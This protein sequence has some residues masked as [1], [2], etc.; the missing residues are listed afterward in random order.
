MTGKY[1]IRIEE[2]NKHNIKIETTDEFKKSYFCRIYESAA[3]SIN[4]IAEKQKTKIDDKNKFADPKEMIYRRDCY[5]YKHRTHDPVN[6]I[7]VFSGERGS[8]KSSALASFVNLLAD[9]KENNKDFDD[10]VEVEELKKLHKG[11]KYYV[12]KTLDP[13]HFTPEKN[14]LFVIISSLFQEFKIKYRANSPGR[15]DI[16]NEIMKLFEKTFKAVQ[17]IDLKHSDQAAAE[18]LGRLDELS[19]SMDL[20]ENI[21]LLVT[22]FMKF[23]QTIDG[24][25]FNFFVIPIDDLDMNVDHAFEMLEQIRKFLIQERIIIL[26]AANVRQLH[27]E[28]EENYFD[29]YEK[30]FN[31]RHRDNYRDIDVKR[32]A[33]DYMSKI[34]PPSRRLEIP[35]LDIDFD[36]TNLEIVSKSDA[37]D[38]KENN[39]NTSNNSSDKDI[40]LQK[41]ILDMI[42]K[43]TGLIFVP[44]ENQLHP[45]IP[46]NLR[47]LHQLVYL[48]ISM[49]VAIKKEEEKIIVDDKE[50][51][52]EKFIIDGE[53]IKE[54]FYKFKDYIMK[55]WIPYHLASKQ[56]DIFEN[57][58]SD[59]NRINKY[60]L[61]SINA[62]GNQFKEKIVLKEVELEN[63]F[64]DEILREKEESIENTLSK[65]VGYLV[66]KINPE[67]YKEN[68][69]VIEI[70][71]LMQDLITNNGSNPK[72]NSLRYYFEKIRY[73]AKSSNICK[74]YK[75]INEK[76]TMEAYC[77]LLLMY[78]EAIEKLTD[79]KWLINST[80]EPIYWIRRVLSQKPLK[81]TVV[82]RDIYTMVS[83]NDPNF[84]DVNKISDPFN[85]T[86]NNSMGDILLLISKYETYFESEEALSFISAVKMY[87]SMLLYENMFFKSE[88]T[89]EDPEIGK[90]KSELKDLIMPIQLLIG[91]TTYFPHAV[92]L[93]S[94]KID[95]SRKLT[96]SEH[97]F[98]FQVEK[99]KLD[100]TNNVLPYFIQYYGARRPKRPMPRHIYDTTY[101]ADVRD[102]E[103]EKIGEK[104]K[105]RFDILSY[106][107]NTLNPY[108][109]HY[110]FFNEY[111]EENNE[112]TKDQIVW[113]KSCKHL[114][115][116][117]DNKGNSVI[118]PI[119]FLPLYSVDIMLRLIRYRHISAEPNF[120]RVVED[121]YHKII[122]LILGWLNTNI[123]EDTE[124]YI[125]KIISVNPICEEIAVHTANNGNKEKVTKIVLKKDIL[126]DT[127][128]S[129]FPKIIENSNES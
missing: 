77:L 1:T 100:L 32:M 60:L 92:E 37:E 68:K 29:F 97:D 27:L 8:G 9:N 96:K 119:P 123:G 113:I 67:E 91:G 4:D 30:R 64:D 34:I 128:N 73:Y 75:L 78:Q 46:T 72:I 39:D 11:N 41:T 47:S 5:R 125:K 82:D 63:R 44:E 110:R 86:S 117:T 15:K 74:Y 87:Y 51:T 107:V 105:A 122:G 14:I 118:P 85:Y 6:N 108:F 50:I 48:M 49:D 79:T 61:Q 62:V 28:L 66:E 43:R 124:K 109:T 102:V 70:K 71:N 59:L 81:K 12:L 80:L 42:W 89:V 33:S 56:Q 3:K 16:I 17:N 111:D 99:E 24:I 58:P 19:I 38:K 98:Y 18:S 40:N 55:Y 7:I 114:Y 53:K 21:G 69:N 76:N 126:S 94:C 95:N 88:L 23:M 115:V 112:F 10:S 25:D 101:Q 93:V 57:I 83:V 104:D 36:N 35:H 2:K 13:S 106:L 65:L 54:N 120:N 127:F 121:Y 90:N 52:K 84:Y 31:A 26:M 45:V 116:S 103:D 129:I 20:K 22:E